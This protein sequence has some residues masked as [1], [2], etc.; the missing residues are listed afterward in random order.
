[1]SGSSDSGK[2]LP[3]LVRIRRPQVNPHLRNPF[4][5]SLNASTLQHRQHV[6]LPRLTKRQPIQRQRLLQ[7][8]PPLLIPTQRKSHDSPLEP[9][10]TRVNPVRGEVA[11]PVGFFRRG[12]FK[13]HAPGL[14][15]R[16]QCTTEWHHQ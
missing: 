10:L 16:S 3:D 11:Q 5:I 7:P 4:R 15:G 9:G 12:G 8:R 1:M 14:L 13:R 2:R 6:L